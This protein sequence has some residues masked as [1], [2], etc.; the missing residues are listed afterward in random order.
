MIDLYFKYLC[1]L[2]GID[3]DSVYSMLTSF[4]MGFPYNYIY[5]MDGN[6]EID[7][8][9]LRYKFGHENGI[10]SAVI[11]GEIDNRECSVLEMLIALS[12]RA[13]DIVTSEDDASFIFWSFIENLGLASQ[14]NK[15]FDEDYCHICISQFLNHEYQPDGRGGLVTIPNPPT[16]LRYVEIWDQVMWWLNDEF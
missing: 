9:N 1:S 2:V 13:N 10:P 15:M 4:L 14:T 11:A 16:D 12:I 3:D 8:I 5:A 6:R 7:G